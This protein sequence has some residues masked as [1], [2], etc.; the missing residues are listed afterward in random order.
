MT[1]GRLFIALAVSIGIAGPSQALM[2]THALHQ[3]MWGATIDGQVLTFWQSL[4]ISFGLLG[5]FTMSFIDI[6]IKKFTSK[7]AEKEGIQK[8]TPEP[9]VA[10][11]NLD[12]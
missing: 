3:A 10:A 11:S 12:D 9:K 2:S 8:V 5:V 4:G 7:K 1:L 6:V